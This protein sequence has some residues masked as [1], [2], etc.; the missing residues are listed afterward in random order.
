MSMARALPI[1]LLTAAIQRLAASCPQIRLGLRVQRLA[2]EMG[3]PVP[4]FEH[5]DRGICAQ[6]FE[7]LRTTEALD[8]IDLEG[9]GDIRRNL[10][11]SSAREIGRNDRL[12][13][14]VDTGPVGGALLHARRDQDHAIG[15]CDAQGGLLRASRHC[16]QDAP[17]GYRKGWKGSTV[18]HEPSLGHAG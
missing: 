18:R 13:P 16:R 5:A 17:N 6:I 15:P 7:A 14:N 3:A 10:E 9:D 12:A 1:G 2:I 11:R 4:Q 8:K